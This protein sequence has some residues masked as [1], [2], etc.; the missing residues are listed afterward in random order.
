MSN[1]VSDEEIQKAIKKPDPSTSDFIFQQTMFRIKDPRASLSFYTGV[2]GMTLLKKLDFP[3]MKFSLY[4]L[5]FVNEAD[6]PKDETVRSASAS[7]TQCHI[8]ELCLGEDSVVFPAESHL[9]A[10]PQLGHRDR[11]GTISIP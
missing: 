7:L 6:I 10:D 2:L 5:G 1:P 9:G 4:F 8:H 11:R 3:E